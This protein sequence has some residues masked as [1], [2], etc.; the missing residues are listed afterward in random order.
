MERDLP[1][2]D[3][4]DLPLPEQ[5]DAEKYGVIKAPDSPRMAKAAEIFRTLERGLEKG[6]LPLEF[7]LPGGGIAQVLERKAY[8]EDPSAFEYAMAGLDATDIVPGAAPLKAVLVG[9]SAKGAKAVRDR[10]DSLRGEGIEDAQEVWNAQEGKKYRGYYSPSD[11]Q[12]RMEIDTSKADL[13]KD[14]I[15]LPTR[16]SKDDS[17]RLP[18]VLK[19]DDLFDQVPSLKD[20]KVKQLPL[21]NQLQGTVAAYDD[22]T[23]T[24]FIPGGFKDLKDNIAKSR[25]SALLHEVQHAVQKREGFLQGYSTQRFTTDE[26]EEAFK[27]ANKRRQTF[28]KGISDVAKEAGAKH[29]TTLANKFAILDSLRIDPELLEKIVTT[30]RYSDEG[31]KLKK[32]F[33]KLYAQRTKGQKNVIPAYF[34]LDQLRTLA[35]KF[36]N[37]LQK[38]YSVAAEIKPLVKGFKEADAEYQPLYQENLRASEMYMRVPGEVEARTV[39]RT[40]EGKEGAGKELVPLARGD[41]SPE[42]YFYPLDPE[43]NIPTKKAKGGG[44]QSLAPIAKDMF[45][46]Y[47]DVKR[48]VGSYIPYI[49]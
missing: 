39:Q 18:D 19:F 4:L 14:D 33:E 42:E 48:G 11:G 8:G 31:R 10:V 38:M 6:S 24:I 5:S 46:G 29:S 35:D 16:V 23:D 27:E 36:D 41:F 25:L 49:K 13:T 32:E 9:M 15:K 22:V 20:V 47:D 12:F 43:Y 17:V 2:V 7:L 45:R 40:F 3:P 28:V 1:V 34:A 30:S 44:V 37:N 26:F 21:G